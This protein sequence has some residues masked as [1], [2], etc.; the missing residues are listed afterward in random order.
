MKIVIIGAGPAGLYAGLLI[1]KAHPSYDISIIERNPAE[2]TYG[3]G[4]VFSDRTL[5]S[6]Q[7]ADY[8]TYEQ[9]RDHFVIWNDIDTRYRGETIR[10]GGHVIASISRKLLLNIL[11]RRCAEL[12]I[13]LTFGREIFGLSELGAYDLLIAADGINS[14]VR[15]AYE[16]IFK[17]S[18][19]LGKAR[20]IWLGA[21]KVLDAFTFIFRENE[22]GLFQ[23]H[24]Y[25]FSGTTSTFIVE[26]DEATWLSAGL[27]QADEAQS[28][29]FCQRLLARDLNGA[30]LLSNNSKWINFAT[31]KTQHW[32]HQNIVLL[33]DAA[34]TAHFSIGSGTKLAME[35][36]IALAGA[37]EEH[38]DLETALNEYELERKPVVET[39][40][41]AAQE[42]Q[43]YFETLKRYLGLEPMQFT[44][45]LLT[46][47]GRI[48]YDD[49][50]LRDI[51]FVEAVDRWFMYRAST[52]IETKGP[53]YDYQPMVVPPTV[54]QGNI[55]PPPAFAPVQLRDLIIPN[56]LVFAHATHKASA[57]YPLE[58]GMLS[59]DYANQLGSLAL[60]GAGLVITDFVAVSAGGRITPDCPGMYDAS[61]E[62]AWHWMICFFHGNTFAKLALQLNHAGRRGSTRSR[63]EGLDRPLRD[64][65][66]P[67][68]S[69][70]SLPYTPQSQVP[71]AMDR[72][73]MEQ[74]RDDFVRAAQMAGEAGIDM[75]QLC[76]G[77]GYLLASFLSPL[78][79]KRTDEYGG[80]LQHRMRYPLE[81]FD[82]V[83]AVWPQGKPISVALSI[84]DGV[85][86][87]FMI[88][89]AIIVAKTLKERGC[90]II[91][92]LAGQTTMDG[93][94]AYGRGFLTA[95][96]DRV[97]NEAGIPTMV[98][99]YLTSSNEVNTILA[100]G[101][102]D[103][104]LIDSPYLNDTAWIT[105]TNI[106]LK[107]YLLSL[108]EAGQLERQ[109][110]EHGW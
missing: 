108:I 83:R 28:L 89:D 39:F 6:F 90:D 102:A 74:V 50:R 37:L 62:S 12:G 17:P 60:A 106:D 32:H 44:F 20:Y 51:H 107:H 19:E 23:V 64:G 33:G 40:Q 88:E 67:L 75:L 87:G 3:W 104:C 68:L 49:L 110:E 8:K 56:R 43:T 30:Q 82:A 52:S 61:H 84:T 109:V 27:D 2:V 55:A 79:N 13:S 29:A 47:S 15:K 81:V 41:R 101:R 96:S 71:E 22:H 78:T 4:V 36:A 99:G 45:Q 63:A 54:A 42:S 80:D 5:A 21:N 14:I 105:P 95:L 93:E 16:S 66:W 76:M 26:C 35:D 94:P 38:S 58:D 31:L 7:R 77:H 65:N 70:S 85:K 24:A 10:C 9:I 98:A 48:T 92:V 72:D 34:H 57:Y 18:I 86:G 25:P 103:L 11:Q 69:A 1:K 91:Q 100:A 59:E 73:D 97:R 46:R 53:Y